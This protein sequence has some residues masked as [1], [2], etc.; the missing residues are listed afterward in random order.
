MDHAFSY[1]MKKIHLQMFTAND[2]KAVRGRNFKH[3]KTSMGCS[4]FGTVG[5]EMIVRGQGHFTK[6]V[7]PQGIQPVVSKDYKTI[8][9]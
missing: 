4:R 2:C 3:F 8:S 6:R 9:G 5:T 7:L 1:N